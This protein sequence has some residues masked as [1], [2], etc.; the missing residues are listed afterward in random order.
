MGRVSRRRP[1]RAAKRAAEALGR[2]SVHPAASRFLTKSLLTCLQ[3]RSTVEFG[4]PAWRPWKAPSSTNPPIRP[5]TAG[6]SELDGPTLAWKNKNR[7]QQG[8][9][10]FTN[11]TRVA[12]PSP[13]TRG[14][15]TGAVDGDPSS[16]P[17]TAVCRSGRPLSADFNASLDI[18][19]RWPWART[20]PSSVP[21]IYLAPA[22][23]RATCLRLSLSVLGDAVAA[24]AA[25]GK[26]GPLFPQDCL[27]L[28]R[29]WR[30]DAPSWPL[31]V[32]VLR[33][34]QEKTR[35]VA[36][37]AANPS[38]NA[39]QFPDTLDCLAAARTEERRRWRWNG[40]VPRA[41]SR[42]RAG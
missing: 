18:R 40:A 6:P 3:G 42:S 15:R 21:S 41:S 4:R 20:G 36:P 24:T 1:G 5:L 32:R 22:R 11:G 29:N 27:R 10:T 35:S 8:C 2:L 7:H 39:G 19:P 28:S 23:I 38:R 31:T 37:E 25:G 17:G 16:R 33:P 9:F 34:P 26:C 14:P 13:E 30:V 12:S